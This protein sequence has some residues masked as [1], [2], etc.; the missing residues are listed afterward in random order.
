MK[1]RR[2]LAS[3]LA[4][5]G[6]MLLPH[7]LIAGDKKPSETPNIVGI[8][9]GGMGG[10]YLNNLEKT[11]KV[12][13]LADVDLLNHAAKT[14][15]HY[16]NA[17]TYVDYRKLLE[18][19]KSIDGVVVG[20][21]DHTH[22][23]IVL[24]ALDLG[25]PVYCAKPLTRTIAEARAV[26]K[27]AAEA[28]VA[29]QMSIQWNA[30]EAHRLIAEW[31]ADGAIGQVTEVH[32]WSNRPVWPQA[33]E[34]PTDTPPIPKG[35]NWDLWLGPAPK[36]PF[37]SAYHPFKWRGWLDFGCGALGDMGCHHMDP[38]FRALHLKNPISVEAEST[39]TFTETFPKEATATYQFPARDHMPPVKLVWYDGNRKPARPAELEE[40]RKMS[41]H[42]GGTLYVGDRGKIL[43]GGLGDG[44]R[45]IPEEKMKN[46]QRP[47]KTLE[48]SPG[49]YEEWA[50]AIK[51]GPKCGADFS[52][53]G[54]LTEAVLLGNEAILKGRQVL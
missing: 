12:V 30:K 27:K 38:I 13:A 52:Y 25:K 48:R 32:T 44:P 4:T 19:E 37:H 46:Y 21:P 6:P 23:E 40:G 53:G 5:V 31:I 36:R 39:P 9:V 11:C 14:V 15:A 1:R 34:R 3:G 7:R 26:T 24:A 50:A 8:G 33:L 10:A 18:K 54:P 42:Y 2:F 45:L 22:A 49:H 41:D 47:A 51:G 28:N 16:S 17:K 29:T 35:M 20:T 43:T